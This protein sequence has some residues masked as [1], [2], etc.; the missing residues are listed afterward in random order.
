MIIGYTWRECVLKFV[1][2]EAVHVGL[3]GRPLHSHGATLL[4]ELERVR[5]PLHDLPLDVRK[6]VRFGDLEHDDDR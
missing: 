4:V 2:C 3:L 1:V 5:I 6:V